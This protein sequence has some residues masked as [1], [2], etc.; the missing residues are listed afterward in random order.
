MVEMLGGSRGFLSHRLYIIGASFLG[1]F[2]SLAD[3]NYYPFLSGRRL[4]IALV[5]QAPG[6]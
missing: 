5:D 2:Q 6:G 4:G 3:S 1:I